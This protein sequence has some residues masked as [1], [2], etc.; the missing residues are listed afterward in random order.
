MLYTIIRIFKFQD[1][2]DIIQ[3]F[4]I[5]TDWYNLDNWYSIYDFFW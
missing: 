3:S 5:I 2:L 1:H 4:L